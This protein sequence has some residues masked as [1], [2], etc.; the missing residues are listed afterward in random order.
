MSSAIIFQIQS[1]LIV[2]LFL[3]GF[4]FRKV[5]KIHIPLMATAI[6][7]D[8]VLILQIE[9]TRSA[10]N[11]AMKVPSNPGLLNFHVSI[12]VLTVFLYVFMGRTGYLL[13]KGMI[14]PRRMH[15]VMGFLTIICRLSTYVTSF[16]IVK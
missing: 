6:I 13:K 12:A 5:R 15:K 7:W 3:V 14:Q 1:T 10:I 16:F 11:K 4:Y 8:I 2:V 9:F